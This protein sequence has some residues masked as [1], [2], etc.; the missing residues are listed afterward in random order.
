MSVGRED[1]ARLDLTGRQGA[2]V[3]AY[4]VNATFKIFAAGA[5]GADSQRTIGRWNQPGL[6][7][8]GNL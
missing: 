6:R 5:V 1:T 8:L 7:T 2:I 3:D 4:L